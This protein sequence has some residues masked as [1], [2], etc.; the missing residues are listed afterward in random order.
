MPVYYLYC[1]RVGEVGMRNTGRPF[2]PR[3]LGDLGHQIKCE[4]DQIMRETLSRNKV[5]QAIFGFGINGTLR[6]VYSGTEEEGA[7]KDRQK[8]FELMR[9]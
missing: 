6:Q 9:K 4:R 7:E 3:K 5:E 8:N 1:Q 2:D